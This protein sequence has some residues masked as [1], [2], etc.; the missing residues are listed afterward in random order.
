[1]VRKPHG[2]EIYNFELDEQEYGLEVFL[3]ENLKSGSYPSFKI[4]HGCSFF[5][6][7]R[8][9]RELRPVQDKIDRLNAIDYQKTPTRYH[10]FSE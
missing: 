2:R 8:S 10:L 7:K 3:D 5:F 4:L 6:I 1:M 9:L